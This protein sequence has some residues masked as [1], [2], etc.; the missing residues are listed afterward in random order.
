MDNAA[1]AAGLVLG[2]TNFFFHQ[3]NACKR[4]T[5]A[6]SSA[7][8]ETNNSSTDYC[9]IIHRL[10]FRSLCHWQAGFEIKRRQPR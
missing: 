8:R 6:K 2:K 1:I 5:T 3:Q 7:G 4:I 9:E 10:P